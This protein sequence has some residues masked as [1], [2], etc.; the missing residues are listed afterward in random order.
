MRELCF[1]FEREEV[2]LV[3]YIV[4]VEAFKTVD[5]AVDEEKNLRVF[6]FRSTPFTSCYT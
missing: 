2:E 6:A 1:K 4:V 5:E 3:K